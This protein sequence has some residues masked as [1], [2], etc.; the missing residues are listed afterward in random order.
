M[1]LVDDLIVVTMLFGSKSY[2]I[3]K[4]VFP[5]KMSHIYRAKACLRFLSADRVRI[6][7]AV[8]TMKHWTM[9]VRSLDEE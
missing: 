9:K 5:L 3:G 8:V 1:C 6:Y 4:P 7:I 2:S